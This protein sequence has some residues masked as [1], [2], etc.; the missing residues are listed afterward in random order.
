[1]CSGRGHGRPSSLCWGSQSAEPEGRE[2]PSWFEARATGASPQPL[3]Q[4]HGDKGTHLFHK[5]T[6]FYQQFLL[7][8]PLINVNIQILL[9]NYASQ[10]QSAI[11]CAR[12]TIASAANKLEVNFKNENILIKI[13]GF[14]YESKSQCVIQQLL[15]RR[16]R[17]YSYKGKPSNI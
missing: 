6:Y 4:A 16:I 15:L 1:M 7:Q 3:L 5:Y 9:S 14:Y 13:S 2:G 12:M 8:S 11:Y 10:P 17:N